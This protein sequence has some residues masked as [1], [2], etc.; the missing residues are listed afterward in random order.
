M[1]AH[2]YVCF[3]AHLNKPNSA[4]HSVWLQPDTQTPAPAL[5]P[6]ASPFLAPFQTCPAFLHLHPDPLL[7][8]CFGVR[9]L[10]RAASHAGS[11]STL[12]H[13]RPCGVVPVRPLPSLHT[14]ANAHLVPQTCTCL[15]SRNHCILTGP[16]ACPFDALVA[17]ATQLLADTRTT[18]IPM[19]PPIRPSTQIIPTRRPRRTDAVG[20]FVCVDKRFPVDMSGRFGRGALG[21]SVAFGML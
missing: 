9:A 12:R 21:Q 8:S 7:A 11:P 17:R 10:S 3:I 19:A 13:R 18:R 20:P 16:L 5:L 1:H 6:Q 4:P 2:V 14:L 15:H